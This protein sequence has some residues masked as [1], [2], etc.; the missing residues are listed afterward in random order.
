MQD[1]GYKEVFS[2][3]ISSRQHILHIPE[4]LLEGIMFRVQLLSVSTD[5]PDSS[6]PLHHG[7]WTQK[8]KTYLRKHHLRPHQLLLHLLLLLL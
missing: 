4:L 1:R 7:D 3:L 8:P 5:L 2:L 6:L